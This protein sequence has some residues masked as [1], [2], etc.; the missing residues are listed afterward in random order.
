[1][2]KK[3]V[4]KEMDDMKNKAKDKMEDMKG[5]KMNIFDIIIE[6]HKNFRKVSIKLEETTS[7]AAKTRRDLFTSL[8]DEILA[9]HEAEEKVLFSELY[10]HKEIKDWVGSGWKSHR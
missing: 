1:M 10:K 9:H 7:R 2:D 8:K 4:G 6:E 5:I 3:N